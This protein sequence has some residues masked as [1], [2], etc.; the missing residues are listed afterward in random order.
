MVQH[1]RGQDRVEA[2]ILFAGAIEQVPLLV[3]RVSGRP[4]RPRPLQHRCR[5]VDGEQFGEPG[6]QQPGVHAGA[7]AEID[8]SAGPC[9]KAEGQPSVDLGAGEL[10]VPVVP[11]GQVVE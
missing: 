4:S 11:A 8:R 7:A 5:H 3:P 2:A 9:G 10:G 1:E 6:G